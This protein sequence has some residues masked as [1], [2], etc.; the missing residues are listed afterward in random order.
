VSSTDEF[1][2]AAPSFRTGQH[3]YHKRRE[4]VRRPMVRAWQTDPSKRDVQA[5]I[6]TG[7]RKERP[8]MLPD[9]VDDEI[10]H[11]LIAEAERMASSRWSPRAVR[12]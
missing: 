12:R 8:P 9:A 10:A 4:K 1:G 11:V 2:A 5:H 7:H 3:E 6:D